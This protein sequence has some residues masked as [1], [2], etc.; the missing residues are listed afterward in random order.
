MFYFISQRALLKNLQQENNILIRGVQLKFFK[1]KKE[2]KT[3]GE[4]DPVHHDKTV[5]LDTVCFYNNDNCTNKLN[6]V[7]KNMFLQ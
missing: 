6:H 3:P 5:I 1:R 7:N 2:I 4:I